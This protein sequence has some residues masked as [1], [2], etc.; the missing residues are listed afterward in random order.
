M[1]GGEYAYNAQI[2][3][4]EKAQVIFG[5]HLRQQAND[6]QEVSRALDEVEATTGRQPEK[7]SPDNG[8]YSGKNLPELSDREIETDVA[9]G[10]G[11]KTGKGSLEESGRRLV[12]TDFRYD[13]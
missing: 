4:D 2:S 6:S 3:V 11:E 10:R 13:E 1:G 7:L 5:Q 8:Y 12:K 9:T